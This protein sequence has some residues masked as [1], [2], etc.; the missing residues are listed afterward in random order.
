MQI[1]F[2]FKNDFF[3]FK[4]QTSSQL[5]LEVWPVFIET[6]EIDWNGPKFFPKW[7]RVGY[8]SD[9]FTGTV[10]SDHYNWNRMELIILNQT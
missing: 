6:P 3:F 2:D 8:C 7:N 10:F 4:L 1:C 5:N 9:L